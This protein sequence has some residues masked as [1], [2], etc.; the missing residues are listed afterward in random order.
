LTIWG[1]DGVPIPDRSSAT[2]SSTSS[3]RSHDTSSSTATKTTTDQA[4]ATQVDDEPTQPIDG[5]LHL[6][7][8]AIGFV[9][10]SL[11]SYYILYI[12]RQSARQQDSYAFLELEEDAQ[13]Y[14]GAYEGDEYR[15]DGADVN[16]KLS[17]VVSSEVRE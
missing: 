12:R 1:E 4:T 3:T 17:T 15:G 9:C 13:V 5:N 10:G 6:A 14:G 2:P 16:V 8:F 7:I 11:L